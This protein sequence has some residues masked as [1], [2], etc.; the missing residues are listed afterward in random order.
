MKRTFEK[1]RNLQM[2]DMHSTSEQ[3]PPEAESWTS[4]IDRHTH[5]EIHVRTNKNAR[6]FRCGI[7]GHNGFPEKTPWR[8]LDPAIDQLLQS[9]KST[10]VEIE[11]IE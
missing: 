8:P 1:A 4:T 6:E 5:Y 7:L 2:N 11:W 3:S 9:I 10:P